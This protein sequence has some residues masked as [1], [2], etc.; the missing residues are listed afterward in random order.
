MQNKSIQRFLLMG[1]LSN[2]LNFCVYYVLVITN[3]NLSISSIIGY[4]SG[5]VF[6]YHLSRVWV[7]GQK[8][9]INANNILRFG[10]VY[11]IGSIWM[12]VIINVLVNMLYIDFRKSWIFGAG[13][14]ALNNYLGLKF[15]VFKKTAQ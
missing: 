4:I 13:V 15:L 5:L 8:F 9:D 2:A 3:I 1:M 12:V 11:F 7:F 6:S 14:T 10:G